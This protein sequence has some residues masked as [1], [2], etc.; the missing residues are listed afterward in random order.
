MVGVDRVSRLLEENAAV[1]DTLF[2]AREQSYCSS[3][4]RRRL[5][6]LAARFAAKE[7]VLKAVGTGLGQRMRWTDVEIVNEINGRPGVRLHGE[8]AAFAE[9]RH[10]ADLDV[11][12][13]HSDGVAM[14]HAVTVW[15]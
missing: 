8:V 10:L 11:S 9:R 13:A 7:A 5:E 4:R 1:M 6:H 14:A 3:R 2:T 15:E 12:L